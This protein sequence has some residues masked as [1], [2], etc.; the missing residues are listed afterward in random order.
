MD[1]KGFLWWGGLGRVE[2]SRCWCRRISGVGVWWSTT[3]ISHPLIAGGGTLV[4]G[5]TWVARSGYVIEA[6]GRQIIRCTTPCGV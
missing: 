3:G 4:L 5:H 1:V 2:V 6:E